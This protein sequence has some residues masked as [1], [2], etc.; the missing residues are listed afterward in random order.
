M[1]DETPGQRFATRVIHGGQRPDPLTG[2]I[3]PPIY[4]TSTYVQSSPGVHQGYEYSR[5]R[6]PTRDAL[7]AAVASLEG[8]AAGFAF[9]SGM[10]ASATVLELLDAGSHIVAMHDLYGGS[11]RLLENVRKRSAGHRVSFVDLSNPAALTSAILP[12]TRLVWVESPTNPLLKLVDLSAVAALARR[13]RLLAVCDN[14]FATPFIQRPLEHGFDIVVH[15]TTKYLNGHSDA[16]G[17]AAIVRDPELAER[18]AYL[19]NAVGGVPGPFDAF[20]TLRGIKTLALRM[21]RHC[22]NA[23]AIAQFLEQHPGVERV[24][25]PGLASHPQHSLARA[26]M[27]GGFGGIVTAV[28]RG[29]LERARRTLERCRLFAL[30]ESLG[31]V[32]SLIEH[33]GIMTHSSLPAATRE[34]LGISDGLIRLSVGVEDVQD[35]IAELRQALS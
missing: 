7:Q 17:G 13:H 10:A 5:T 26:Q 29:G 18:I 33:P 24:Y 35:L 8:G 19:Q 25:Y 22:A 28:V 21:E 32:E 15:S 20:L 11:Y 34:S 31:G 27:A 6:N 30:A 14:T 1:S 4:A 2:A 23:L 16:I 3:M 9:A 12:D